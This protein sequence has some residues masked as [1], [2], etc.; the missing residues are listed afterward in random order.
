MHEEHGAARRSLEALAALCSA[1]SPGQR[2]PRC[3]STGLHKW[4]SFAD[5]RRYRCLGC[6]HTF[7]DLTHTPAAYSKRIK[8]WPQFV[9]C[10]RGALPLRLCA[11]RLKISLS[12]AFRWRH[13]VLSAARHADDTTLNGRV[14]LDE[15]RMAH[16]MKGRRHLDR[17]ARVRGARQLDPLLL[18]TR[19]VCVII[20]H[21]QY[22][23]TYSQ[24]VDVRILRSED[25][26][27]VLLPRV[28]KP[29]T[30]V[31]SRGPYSCHAILARAAEALFHSAFPQ[32]DQQLRAV[33]DFRK[34]IFSFLRPFRGVAT[35][36]LDNYLR[37]HRVLE[38]P[39]ARP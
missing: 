38:A 9:E 15:L 2:C 1:V 18:K 28:R 6:R 14:E 24:H 33:T 16:S 17:P 12:T 3:E 31:S 5:R 35:K 7:S 4:G 27:S 21:D 19:R 22:G 32:I 36:Y 30:I 26:C 11:A 23:R 20:A 37:W 13:A 34:R 25:L 29:L 8:L 10:M 39:S